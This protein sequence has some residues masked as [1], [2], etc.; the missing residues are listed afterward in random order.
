MPRSIHH[1]SHSSRVPCEHVRHAGGDR[2]L[3]LCAGR[4]RP[5]MTFRLP[6]VL[7]MHCPAS[8]HESHTVQYLW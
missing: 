6:L 4:A 2:A 5:A 1:D 3:T 8:Y 7:V